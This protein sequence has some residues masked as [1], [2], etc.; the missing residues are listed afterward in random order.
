MD[1]CAIIADR[2]IATASSRM[3]RHVVRTHPN[4]PNYNGCFV[5]LKMIQNVETEV[6]NSKRPAS[7]EEAL[8]K[9]EFHRWQ[10]EVYVCLLCRYVKQFLDFFSVYLN[11]HFNLLS[12]F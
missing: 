12:Y 6:R 5:K 4:S 2:D 9:P 8:F 10:R 7:Y 3:S 11:L 1:C